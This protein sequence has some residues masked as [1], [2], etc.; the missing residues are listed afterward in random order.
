MFTYER[1]VQNLQDVPTFPGIDAQEIADKLNELMQIGRT[2]EGGMHRFPYTDTETQA[3]AVFVRWMQEVKLQVREDAIGNLYGLYKGQDST[4]PVVMTGSHLDSVPN[5]GAFDGPL[6]C[7][8][9]LLA[10]KAMQERGIQPKRGIEVVVFVD[11]EGARFRNGIFGSRVLMGEVTYQDLLRFSDDEGVALVDAMQE[12]GFTAEDVQKHTRR[13]EEIHAFLELHIEQGVKL[14]AT[15]TD[16][17]VV[18]GIAGPAW[19]TAT[20]KGNTDH[21]GNTPMDARKDTVPAAAE[22][23]LAVEKFPREINETAVAT[24]GKLHVHPNGS[25][26]I[27]GETQ[28]TVDVRDIYEDTRAELLSRIQQAAYE[29]AERRGLEVVVEQDVQIPPV[30]V[31]DQ[32]QQVIREAAEKCGLSTMPLVSGAGHDAMI[33]GK[34]VPSGMVFVPSH[35]GKSHSPDEW[36]ELSDCVK[37]VAVMTEALLALAEN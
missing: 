18:E 35:N 26:V 11:E 9:S 25:N 1:L 24:V 14:E 33:M 36:T 20:Y 34:Y 10:I 6:G 32:V 13:P 29:I 30:L 31:P 8:S 22:L 21:A 27:A 4:L 16:I 12:S 15:G 28:V 7:I 37:G 23:I 2:S 19:L 3:K 5:G 17:G